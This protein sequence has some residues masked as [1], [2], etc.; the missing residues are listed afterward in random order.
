MWQDTLQTVSAG[1]WCSAAAHPRTELLGTMPGPGCSGKSNLLV[2]EP[3]DS[4]VTGKMLLPDTKSHIKVWVL[5]RTACVWWAMGM[6]WPSVAS[7]T[8]TYTD[9]VKTT[10]HECLD[11]PICF[12]PNISAKLPWKTFLFFFS[13][14]LNRSIG[15]RSLCTRQALQCYRITLY[16]GLVLHRVVKAALE[17]DCGSC[18]RQTVCIAPDVL[19]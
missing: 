2:R 15:Q 4:A 5:S 6:S 1:L 11:N 14:L 8:H 13:F 10:G 12:Y 7:L 17:A 3:E 16:I 9:Q 18:G 19:P